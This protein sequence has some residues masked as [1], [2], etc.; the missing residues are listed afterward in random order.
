[1]TYEAPSLVE[2]G[3]LRDL[4]LGKLRP[5]PNADNSTWWGWLDIWGDPAP[6]GSR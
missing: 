1:M 3:S 6:R 5:G 4:T 2:V